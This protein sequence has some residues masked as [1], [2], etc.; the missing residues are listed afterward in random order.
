M[1]SFLNTIQF[2]KT[3]TTMRGEIIQALAHWNL[4][5]TGIAKVLAQRLKDHL[6]DNEHLMSNP[7]FR[8]LFTK[9]QRTADDAEHGP[10]V[11]AWGG[12]AQEERQGSPQLSRGSSPLTSLSP[13]PEDNNNDTLITFGQDDDAAAIQLLK[14]FGG[15]SLTG[16]VGNII[17]SG[18]NANANTS[19]ANTASTAST[20]KRPARIPGLTV[21][22]A[23]LLAPDAIRKRFSASGGWQTHVPLHVLTDK[24]CL[25]AMQDSSGK[26][27]NDMFVVDSSTGSTVAMSRDLPAGPEL[28]L[29]YDEWDQAWRC[30]LDLI[31]EFLPDEL[32]IWKTHHDNIAKRPNRSNLWP[33][34][35]EYDARI[36]RSALSS[37]VDP[38]YFQYELWNEL[39]AAYYGK[40]AAEAAV[41]LTQDALKASHGSA[42]SQRGAGDK[43]TSNSHRFRVTDASPLRVIVP[44]SIEGSVTSDIRID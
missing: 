23:R 7:N 35:L 22:S 29:T 41:R 4:D 21:S 31:G 11:G 5:A 36:R 13:A 39:E 19:S 18:N 37:G 28:S 12:L 20:R 24:A 43:D 27:F 30:L 25:L 8:P 1:P 6:R 38:T 42:R 3:V 9:T 32:D 40:Q 44:P 33:V 16:F 2:K 34:Y 10:P 14:H 17:Q 26:L 15:G